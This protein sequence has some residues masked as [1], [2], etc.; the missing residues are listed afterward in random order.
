MSNK[1]SEQEKTYIRLV[2]KSE[3]YI[4]QHL[5]ESISLKELADNVNYSEYH[6]HRIFTKYS[7]ETLKHFISRFKLERAAIF[8]SINQSTSLTTIALNYG[9]NNSSSFSRA[10]KRHF[11]SSPS[12]YRKEQEMA[13]KKYLTIT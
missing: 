12:V 5:N 2:N 9:Y 11:G 4:E 1:D 7:N 3:D 8:M 10:F 13:R 6:F